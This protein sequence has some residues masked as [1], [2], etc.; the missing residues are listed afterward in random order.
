M[1]ML[2]CN[3]RQGKSKKAAKTFLEKSLVDPSSLK[4]L[5]V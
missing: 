4:D 2:S 1:C 3:S 5:K